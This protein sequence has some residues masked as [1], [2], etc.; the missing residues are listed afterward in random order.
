MTVLINVLPDDRFGCRIRIKESCCGTCERNHSLTLPNGTTRSLVAA[1]FRTSSRTYFGS[2]DLIIFI[3]NSIM[4]RAAIFAI[5][6]LCCLSSTVLAAP[7]RRQGLERTS[8]RLTVSADRFSTL[9]AF[10]CW[11]NRQ[12]I[13]AIDER[14]SIQFADFEVRPDQVSGRGKRRK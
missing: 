13:S 7:H 3:N 4:I 5:V 1:L 9:I 11:L 10:L 6:V 8:S 12:N 14:E 2:I